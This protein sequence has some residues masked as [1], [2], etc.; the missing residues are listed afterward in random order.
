MELAI[1][2]DGIWT[3]SALVAELP[4]GRHFFR[5]VCGCPWDLV[6]AENLASFFLSFF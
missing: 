1:D 4:L 2:V 5:F 3:K 6:N